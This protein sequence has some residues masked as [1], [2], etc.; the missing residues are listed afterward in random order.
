MPGRWLKSGVMDVLLSC[1]PSALGTAV[2]I[3]LRRSS[4]PNALFRR[5][6]EKDTAGVGIGQIAELLA[7]TGYSFYRECAF[8][9]LE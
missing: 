6:G 3:T 7:E 2:W 8:Q 9:L 1:L 4:S 5:D